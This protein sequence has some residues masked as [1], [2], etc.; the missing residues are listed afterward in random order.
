MALGMWRELGRSPEFRDWAKTIESTFWADIA[1]FYHAGL[2]NMCGPY[3]RGYG[4]D[5]ARYDALLGMCI[6]MGLDGPEHAPLPH[7]RDRGFEWT[8]T[9]LFAL[10]RIQPPE[11]LLSEFK[12]FGEP[13]EVIRQIPYR[14]WVF[15]AQALLER[16]LMMGAATGMRLRW[17]QHCPGTVH[18]SANT[19]GELGWLLVHG[20]N[21][22]ETKIEDR[23]LQIFL[24]EPDAEHP[25]RILV[26]APDMQPK[27]FGANTWKLQGMTFDIKSPLAAPT[28]KIKKD[29]RFGQVI[30]IA[31]PI[32]D[33]LSTHTPVL[34]LTPRKTELSG[35]RE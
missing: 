9:P 19:H 28:V 23:S 16:D 10:L 13:R 21:A 26:H 15:Q 24:P 17:E 30:E 20:E 12:T 29:K 5:M 3:V 35:R 6:A 18:W 7:A 8:Y 25:L 14:H 34:V 11:G 33:S 32:S 2:K 4:M 27:Q 22:A 1:Q 31:F